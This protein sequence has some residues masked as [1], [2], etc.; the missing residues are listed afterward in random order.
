MAQTTPSPSS[1]DPAAHPAF[2]FRLP[3]PSPPP[4]F[5]SPL[6]EF[7]HSRSGQTHAAAMPSAP[8]AQAPLPVEPSR[9]AATPTLRR[10]PAPPPPTPRLS[11][12]R[13][14]AVGA[15]LRRLA[16]SFDW[17]RAFSLHRRLLAGDLRTLRETAENE[18]DGAPTLAVMALAALAGA[19]GAWLWLVFNSGE[20]SAGYAAA[21]V[22]GLGLVCSVAAWAAFAAATW[23]TMQRLFD[24][25]VELQRLAR[26]LALAAGFGVWQLVLLVPGISFAVG[27][28]GL[29]AWFLLSVVAVRAA[30]P[31]LDERGA[32][33]SVG[34][35]FS[36]YVLLL[37]LAANLAGIAPGV[38]VH[39]GY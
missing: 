7:A 15:G 24:V 26:P 1:S 35:G 2:D 14:S 9:V 5:D 32:V 28:L 16:G 10:A 4:A 23:W 17:G 18:T 30:S 29:M 27:L 25:R 11:Q 12:R 31:E 8:P 19:L 3:D 36:V 21:R 20:V 22:V 33:I 6:P 37:T 39:A 13:T 34:I 38:F